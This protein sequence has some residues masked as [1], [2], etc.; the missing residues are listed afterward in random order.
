M[1]VVINKTDKQECTIIGTNTKTS[2]LNAVLVNSTAGRE[3]EVDD[4][5]RESSLYSNS[6]VVPVSINVFEKN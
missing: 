5:Y 2:L 1:E 3:F 4:I 6:I